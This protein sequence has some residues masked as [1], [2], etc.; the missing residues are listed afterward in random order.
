MDIMAAV[1]A[2]SIGAVIGWLV[3]YFI[4]RFRSFTPKSL[5]AVTSV[6]LGGVVVKMFTIDSNIWWM[7]CIGVAVGFLIIYPGIAFFAIRSGGSDSG[8]DS[9]KKHDKNLP[10]GGR[11]DGP[12]FSRNNPFDNDDK[13]L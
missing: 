8:E 5:G 6:I 2:V 13:K 1:G 10:P 9:D 7:Y 4:R 11:F 12:L 3:R